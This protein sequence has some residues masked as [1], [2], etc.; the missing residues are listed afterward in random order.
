MKDRKSFTT[1][2]LLRDSAIGKAEMLACC[3]YNDVL[4]KKWCQ[5]IDSF[6]ENTGF[7]HQPGTSE[8][9]GPIDSEISEEEVKEIFDNAYE[10]AC[11]TLNEEE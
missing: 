5:E 1:T 9:L 8:I 4:Y 3:E 11:K 10:E 2:V 7:W 6:F